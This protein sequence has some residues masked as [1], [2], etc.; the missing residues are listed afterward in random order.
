MTQDGLTPYWPGLTA[1]E[2][3]RE[4]KQAHK[5][6]IRFAQLERK[7]Q[8]DFARYDRWVQ[9]QL[10]IKKGGNT[11]LTP[12]QLDYYYNNPDPFTN[13]HYPWR[14]VFDQSGVYVPPSPGSV[15]GMA[16]QSMGD[17]VAKALNEGTVA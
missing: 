8:Q 7:K 13:K 4:E 11:T 9:R 3:R 5:A 14:W 6:R 2:I 15:S 12:E 17:N 1:A 16:V 10:R